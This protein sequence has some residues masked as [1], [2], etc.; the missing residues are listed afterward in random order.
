MHSIRLH[1]HFGYIPRTFQA[2]ARQKLLRP[3]CLYARSKKAQI[4]RKRE[5]VA[6]IAFDGIL[7]PGKGRKWS[8]Y[9][10]RLT[11]YLIAPPI[12]MWI[13]YEFMIIDY[14]YNYNQRAREMHSQ[15]VSRTWGPIEYSDKI[16]GYFDVGF[17]VTL[18][19]F[20]PSHG[21]CSLSLLLTPSLSP[22]LSLRWA[23]A[24]PIANAEIRVI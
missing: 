9:G 1:C 5:N 21:S 23:H 19:L 12:P 13:I 15:K 24:Q 20:S 17:V 2:N 10:C 8:E 3:V 16:N 4:H 6:N 14:G 11:S 22:S 18:L 7:R